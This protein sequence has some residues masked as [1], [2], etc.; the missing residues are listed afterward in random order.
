VPGIEA[1]LGR[2]LENLQPLPVNVNPSMAEISVAREKAANADIT[3]VATL[4]AMEFPGQAAMVQ[5]LSEQPP[6]LVVAALRSPYDLLM[7]PDQTTYVAIYGE[8][9]PSIDAMAQL[10]CGEIEPK[11]LLPVDLPGLHGFGD[12]LK[13]F[14]KARALTMT[15]RWPM[16]TQP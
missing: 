13:H 4:N 1:A 2:H 9:M 15:T 16:G 7:F 6:P 8:A 12:G 10:L 14:R 3:I 5:A 11:G